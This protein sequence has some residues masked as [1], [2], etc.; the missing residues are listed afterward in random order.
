ML[1]VE[2]PNLLR[3]A[4]VW[5]QVEPV[6][7]PIFVEF[8]VLHAEQEV[9]NVFLIIN[10]VTLDNWEVAVFFCSELFLT[11]GLEIGHAEHF[12]ELA[13]ES[14]VELSLLIKVLLHLL[15]IEL[16]HDEAA[17]DVAGV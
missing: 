1:H 13:A 5:H 3:L 2:H 10:V 12:C 11:H 14:F 6:L 15:A 17:H 9:L 7:K 8:R 4:E 16:V